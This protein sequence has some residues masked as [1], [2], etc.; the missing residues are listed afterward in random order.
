M[1]E[2]V[3]LRLRRY[4]RGSH[5]VGD[6]KFFAS[7]LRMEKLRYTAVN[8]D[9]CM[10]SSRYRNGRMQSIERFNSWARLELAQTL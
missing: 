5:G 6:I 3:L 2:Y 7:T 10:V 9:P 4:R 8:T 1:D